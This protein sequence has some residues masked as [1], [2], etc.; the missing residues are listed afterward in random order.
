M[1]KIDEITGDVQYKATVIEYLK[2]V[3]MRSWH[4]ESGL[5]RGARSLAPSIVKL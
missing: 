3:V 1:K 4:A 5:W 2:V